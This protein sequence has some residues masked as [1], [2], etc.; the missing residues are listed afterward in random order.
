MAD[1]KSDGYEKLKQP[2]WAPD[3]SSEYCTLCGDEFSLFY[4]RHHCR[5][6]GKLVCSTCSDYK[7]ALGHMEGYDN[8]TPYRVCSLCF[9][10]IRAL[11]KQS[12][13]P[14]TIAQPEAGFQ[15]AQD[16]TIKK[17]SLALAK[18]KQQ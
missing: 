3:S 17:K 8:K 7:T 16:S 9:P 15:S 1:S 2:A 10:K 14:E 11:I 4:R 18:S 12:T 13:Q 6:C 5:S